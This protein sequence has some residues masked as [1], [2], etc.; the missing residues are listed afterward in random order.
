MVHGSRFQRDDNIIMEGVDSTIQICRTVPIH[1]V[2]FNHVGKE[3]SLGALPKS[4]RTLL[5]YCLDLYQRHYGSKYRSMVPP[6]KS[7]LWREYHTGGLR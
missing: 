6:N 4:Y 5:Q 3:C 1:G 7:L 2:G